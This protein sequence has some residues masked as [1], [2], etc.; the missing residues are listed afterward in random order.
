MGKLLTFPHG[1]YCV[2]EEVYRIFHTE[3][4]EWEIVVVLHEE[5]PIVNW[6]F[7]VQRQSFAIIRC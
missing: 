6:C 7:V 1:F 2:L 4:C 3:V 5:H